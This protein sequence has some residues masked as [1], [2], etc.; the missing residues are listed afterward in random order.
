MNAEWTAIE[1]AGGW[2][3]RV[4]SAGLEPQPTLAQ[5]RAFCERLVTEPAAMPAVVPLKISA[6]VEVFRTHVDT[7]R[8]RLEVVCK[9]ARGGGVF[10]RLR[11]RWFG[12]RERRAVDRA[13]RLAELGVATARPLALLERGGDPGWLIS[14]YVPDL[15]DL[16]RIALLLTGLSPR[17]GWRV[18]RSLTAALTDLLMRLDRGGLR[19]RDFK[20]GNL[21]AASAEVLAPTGAVRLWLLDLDGLHAGRGPLLRELVRLAASLAPVASLTRTDR[22]RL[23]RDYLRA[24]GEP[25]QRVRTLFVALDAAVRRYREAAAA[26]HRGRIDDA[27]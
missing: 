23:L 19:H 18:R 14:E 24:R 12:P 8:G 20:A 26:R 27:D 13:R 10:Q 21:L 11:R 6:S 5:W 3:A 9:S 17:Q 25:P 15:L 1:L 4:R 22:L 2:R 7:D 16:E